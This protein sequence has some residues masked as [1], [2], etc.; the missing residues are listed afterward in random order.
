MDTI[1]FND[2]FVVFADAQDSHDEVRDIVSGKSSLKLDKIV[3]H[4][5][6]ITIVCDTLPKDRDHIF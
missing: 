4:G 1:F 6:N 3:L 2:D 5:T